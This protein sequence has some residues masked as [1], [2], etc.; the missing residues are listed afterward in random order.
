MPGSTWPGPVTVAM[1]ATRRPATVSSA[2]FRLHARW[3]DGQNHSTPSRRDLLDRRAGSAAFDQR[4]RVPLGL[5]GT[6]RRAAARRA[7][8]RPTPAQPLPAPDDWVAIVRDIPLLHQPC[9]G[10]TYNT[11]Y[12]IAGVL[13]ARASG[14]S[15]ADY[16]DARIFGPL[17]MTDTAFSFP[18]GALDPM[19]AS[20]RVGDDGALAVV[21]TP[22]GRWSANRP[23][24]RVLVATCR[25]LRT[26]SRF[27]RMLL[28]G[29]D[30]V[31]PPNLVAAMMTDQ[32]TPAARATDTV[33]LD[34]P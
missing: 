14:R 2:P 26:C 7:P 6:G 8:P 15:F 1:R 12:D 28:A 19:T 3:Q 25:R 34:G 23:S 24:R 22:N 31:L 21:D 4:A 27:Q 9:R 30:D 20:Y 11:A 18:P 16:F 13:V 32:L 29:G 10:F 5:L 33:F 17:G